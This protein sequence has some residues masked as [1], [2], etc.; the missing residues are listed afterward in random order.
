LVHGSIV[1]LWAVFCGLGGMFL[2]VVL[3]KTAWR[4]YF[5]CMI[6]LMVVSMV[7]VQRFDIYLAEQYSYKAFTQHVLAIVKDDPLYFYREGELAVTFYANKRIP[8]Y[9]KQP[10]RESSRFHLLCWE[11]EW[12]EVRHTTGLLLEYASDTIDRQRPE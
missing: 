11:S 2:I 1:L 9:T 12:K 8:I 10:R 3:T 5:A 6:G 4:P 7:F